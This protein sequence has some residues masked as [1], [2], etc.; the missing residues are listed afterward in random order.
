MAERA[1]PVI[2]GEQTPAVVHIKGP[3][4]HGQD[5]ISVYGGVKWSLTPE[6]EPAAG[7][8]RDV[9]VN[10]FDRGML[11]F[12]ESVFE[13]DEA[14]LQVEVEVW[15]AEPQPEDTAPD[16]SVEDTG[17][18]SRWPPDPHQDATKVF[19]ALGEVTDLNTVT[20][21]D[22]PWEPDCRKIWGLVD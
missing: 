20:I 16:R 17:R 22:W 4:R 8:E 6:H 19:H 5:G 14:G 18:P 9:Q 11:Y 21:N 3:V 13:Q 15:T 10:G 2:E 12:S 7:T 1:V